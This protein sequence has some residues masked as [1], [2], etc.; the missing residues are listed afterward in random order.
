[1]GRGKIE[2]KR[3]ENATGRQ[4]TFSKRTKGLLKKARELS[5]LCDSQVAIVI[6]SSTGRLYRYASSSMKEILEK[7]H[8]CPNDVQ[9]ASLF[10]Y[11]LEFQHEAAKQ[12]LDRCN[13]T[14]RHMLG[15][16]LSDLN[17]NELEELE[18]QLDVGLSLIRLKKN[19]VLLDQINDLKKKES[20]LLEENQV[21]C[22]K[23]AAHH[24]KTEQMLDNMNMETRE[25]PC[26]QTPKEISVQLNH[27]TRTEDIHDLGKLLK[28]G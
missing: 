7:Y 4:V 14:N 1:M 16:E 11:D 27:L 12:E 24:E 8:K 3:I 17:L 21:L 10:S 6:F 18:R 9:R 5:V 19:E 15:E 20:T 26:E 23:I 25:P 13:Q 22:R 2:I 28:L